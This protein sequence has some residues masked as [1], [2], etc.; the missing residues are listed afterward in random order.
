MQFTRLVTQLIR[1]PRSR[2]RLTRWG[3]S[4]TR[5]FASGY[6]CVPCAHY[7]AD[8]LLWFGRAHHGFSGDVPTI[9][10]ITTSLHRAMR[11]AVFRQGEHG[12]QHVKI[13]AAWRSIASSPGTKGRGVST[14]PLINAIGGRIQPPRRC[15]PSR[16]RL[17]AIAYYG[18]QPPV[19]SQSLVPGHSFCG[20][21]PGAINPQ[22]PFAPLPFR[23]AEQAWQ[24]A[25][26][27]VSQQN[28]STQKP[29]IH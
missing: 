7:F 11:Y 4:T 23:V 3:W 15:C 6:G 24:S 28:P 13:I 18:E 29:L 1:E 25:L 12:F 8:R 19:M 27:A 17:F 20:S 5:A 21:V 2:L 10:P 14:R 9:R 16:S 26:H 22:V